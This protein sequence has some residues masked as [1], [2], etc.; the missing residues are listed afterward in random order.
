[1]A[2]FADSMPG[3]DVDVTIWSI[4]EVYSAV[5]CV[6][7]ISIRPLLV[8]YFPKLFPV[9]VPS[10]TPDW[11]P[12]PRLSSRLTGK[13]RSGSRGVE[14][15]SESETLRGAKSDMTKAAETDTS[16][17]LTPSNPTN[18]TKPLPQLP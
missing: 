11:G 14:L 15:L 17:E 10:R 4:I 7:L 6:C 3:D 18:S 12:S 5:I 16:I 1:M 9:T 2:S 13:R 8:K